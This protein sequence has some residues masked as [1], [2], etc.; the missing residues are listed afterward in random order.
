MANKKL[1]V[2][3]TGLNHYY[4]S[5]ILEVGQKCKLVK[6]PENSYDREAIKVLVG[7]GLQVGYV[8]NSSYTV[9]HGTRSAGRLYDK[10]DRQ[11]TA[12]IM[13]IDRNQAIAKVRIR[14]K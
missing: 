10:F 6:E 12:K 11:L 7:N 13:F 9:I 8:A 5:G 14:K 1:Y 4:G 3:I 2:T